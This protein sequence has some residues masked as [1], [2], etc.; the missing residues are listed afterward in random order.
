MKMHGRMEIF[1]HTFI[2]LTL[3]GGEWS[4]SCYSHFTPGER[5]PVSIEQEGGWVPDG[6]SAVEK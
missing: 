5:T 6:F 1:F 2:F 4:A 3:V